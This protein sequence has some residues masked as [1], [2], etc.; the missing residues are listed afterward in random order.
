MADYN[1]KQIDQLKALIKMAIK[2]RGVWGVGCG[3]H[4]T[5]HTVTQA[6]AHVTTIV[7]TIITTTIVM[8]I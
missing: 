1:L 8:T 4:D 6:A 7:T 2:V 5:R 3:D